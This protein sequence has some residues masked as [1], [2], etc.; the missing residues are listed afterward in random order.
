MS[1]CK[2]KTKRFTLP[3]SRYNS[4]L[5]NRLISK[6]IMNGKKTLAQNIVSKTF[7][8]INSRLNVNP[9]KVFEAAIRNVTPAVKIKKAKK[10]E[11]KTY[12]TNTKRD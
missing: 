11:K 1:R 9:L 6:I 5:V 12:Q 2:I 8:I 3:D 7:D 4:Y 10:S